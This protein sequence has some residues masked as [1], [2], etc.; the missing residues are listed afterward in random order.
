MSEDKQNQTTTFTTFADW[1]RHK[2]SLS[3]DARHTVEVLLKRAGTR[4]CDEANRILSSCTQLNLSSEKIRDISPLSPL[5][6]LTSLDLY[7]NNISD[8]SPLSPLTNLTTLILYGNEVRDISPLYSLTNLTSL[9]LNNN[10]I[11]DISPLSLLTNLTSLSLRDNQISDISPLSPLTNLTSLNLN[12][13][14][15]SDISPLSPLTNLTWLDLNRNKISDISPLSPLTNLTSLHLYENLLSDISP[16]S[17]LTNLTSLDLNRNEISDISP[18]RSLLEKW[19]TLSTISID[20]QQAAAA[21]KVAYELIS[22]AEPEIVFCSS[23]YAGLTSLAE[24]K[25][26]KKVRLAEKLSEATREGFSQGL[27]IFLLRGM[28]F[29]QADAIHSELRLDL[30]DRRFYPN[31]YLMPE[32]LVIAISVTEYCVSK[33]GYVLTHKTQEALQCLNQLLEHCGWIWAFEEVCVVCDRPIKLSFESENRLHALGEP[34][35]EFVDGYQLYS[36]HGVTLPEKY[37]K[38]HPE[39][40][41]SQWLL[42]ED[43][44]ELRRLLIQGIGYDRLCQELQATELDTWQEYTL[45]TI[46][47][48]VDEEPIYLL[49][50]TCPS[51][52]FVHALRVPPDVNSA[53]D[54]ICWVNWGVDPEE[55]SIQT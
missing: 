32:D 49:K 45:L 5:T 38:L 44:A 46:D 50:M 30:R 53:R 17:P 29:R 2:D 1:C 25:S 55:F 12:I 40:W 34:A 52:G 27:W 21:V 20:R 41:Q 39:Q 18:Q 8:I 42:E 13:N 15:I 36:Y 4:E 43:N 6:N 23:P 7:N 47:H 19:R 54:A 3:K 51:T 24:Y 28:Q 48:N 11:R 22:Q 9:Y 33:F 37:G 35:I 14:Q 26:L 31:N 10:Q 16:L